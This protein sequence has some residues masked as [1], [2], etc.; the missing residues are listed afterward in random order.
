MLKLVSTIILSLFAATLSEAASD[1]V[2][3]IKKFS[4]GT[5][6]EES[7][8]LE[9]LGANSYRLKIPARKLDENVFAWRNANPVEYIDIISQ[10]ACAAKGDN[11][12][13]VLS[14]GRIGSFKAD[15]GEIDERRNPM[16][17]FGM[18]KG[19]KA[20]VAIIKGLKYEF[21]MRVEVKEGKYKIYP[22]FH[23]KDIGTI[24]Y[25]DIIIDFIHF[26]G[27]AA[28]YS[29]MA[30][31]YRK[32]QLERGEVRPLRERVRGNPQLAYTADS[33]FIRLMMASFMRDSDLGICRGEHFR[34]EDEPPLKK[35][36]DFD[37]VMATM[38]K[39]KAIGI[40][41]AEICL[42]NWNWRSNGRNPVYYIAESE[43]GGDAK[44]ME[45]TACAK[46]LEYQIVPHTLHTESYTISPK[47][48]KEDL[49]VNKDGT[50]PHHGLSMGG[51]AYLNC[52]R[53]FYNKHIKEGYG[54]LLELGFKGTFHIDVTSCIVPYQCFN[55]NHFCTRRDTAD[56]MNK[57]GKITRSYF[58]GFSSEGPCDHVANT[59]DYVLYTSAYPAYIGRETPLMD[60]IAPI[61]QLVYH[62]IILSNPFASTIDYTYPRDR[63]KCWKPCSSFDEPER[64]LKLVEFGGR[65][66]F[67]WSLASTENFEPV[68]KAYDE[69]QPLKYLQY[70]F[71]DFHGEI[72][73]D[74]FK[75]VYSDG[76]EVV[77][78]Y[79]AAPFEYRGKK[80]GSMDYALF[81]GGN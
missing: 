28:N 35:F 21:S 32:Y 47:F 63:E 65:P 10:D 31:E 41:K 73:K 4:D 16:P 52:F 17:I 19:D 24:P 79:S 22:R 3:I 42:V 81:K 13:W 71:M 64:R 56:Y 59:L 75:T 30:K 66:T 34:E 6:K 36:R 8:K 25:E 57:I 7:V 49:A 69:Y 58:G 46:D 37:N 2:K 14:D 78:N 45:A 70:E 5:I 55:L 50:Y 74:V 27:D 12:Y 39:F 9:K 62:G 44:C 23:I 18:K 15:E 51:R 38:K 67:Y 33:I 72:A 29:S 76:S 48:D 68:K 26:E 1:S 54:R 40:E 43:L 61:W 60:R 53:V 11:G 80:I 20:F 77:T